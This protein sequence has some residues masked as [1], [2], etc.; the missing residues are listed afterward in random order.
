MTTEEFRN[1]I[2]ETSEPNWFN[3]LSIELDFIFIKKKF[4]FVSISA[5]YEFVLRQAEG[6]E[7]IKVYEPIAD[8]IS[9]FNTSR[10]SF[11]TLKVQLIDFVT[12]N[13][14]KNVEVLEKQWHEFTAYNFEDA[15]NSFPY[16]DS[17]TIFLLKIAE[18]NIEQ[19]RYAFQF[20]AKTNNNGLIV[21]NR[22]SFIGNSLAFNFVYGYLPKSK[23][24]IEIESIEK[25]KSDFHEYY[26][27]IESQITDLFL[28]SNT[29]FKNVKEQ[30]L[31]TVVEQRGE[32][33]D[34]FNASQETFKTFDEN[35]N[36]KIKELE[37]L[38]KEK[39]SLSAPAEYWN[40]RATMLK[41]EGWLALKWLV[42]LVL[43][44]CITLYF[45]LWQTPEG[46]LKSF[47][48]DDKT[49]AIKWSIVFITFISFLAFGIRALSKV[50]FSSFHLSR[51]AEEREHLTFVY[52]SLAKDSSVEKED[53]LLIMQSL[54]S[55]ADS[56]L[57]KEDSAPT[58]PSIVEKFIQK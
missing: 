57:L 32:V 13:N 35:S 18:Q 44:A 31:K 6:W 48:S 37:E 16:D 40:K 20:V 42:V 49:L 23:N 47:F 5:F 8:E 11:A 41:K 36:T 26:S 29:E 17:L 4:S 25:Q 56:G 55:R 7:G 30:L 46:M 43:F 51:D 9:E 45:L 38:Y 15:T 14:N 39:L 50:M 54:F 10:N 3:S 22:D 1:L 19:F 52:L 53:R 2:L 12:S 28:K 27:S 33:S 21:K 24:N 58:M 34:W